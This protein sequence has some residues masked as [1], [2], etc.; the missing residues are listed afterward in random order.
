MVGRVGE[1]REQPPGAPAHALAVGGHH[2][3]VLLAVHLDPTERLPDA[4]PSQLPLAGGPQV[5]GPL[6]LAAAPDQVAG[7]PVGEWRDGGADRAAAA[8][9][10]HGERRTAEPDRERVDQVPDDEPRRDIR[11]WRGI[12]LGHRILL[13]LPQPPRRP[14]DRWASSRAIP[15]AHAPIAAQSRKSPWGSRLATIRSVNPS[16]LGSSLLRSQAPKNTR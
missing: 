4:A 2:P 14:A 9:T 11:V 7:L 10:H 6:G 13:G 5:A 16:L 8:P 12:G 3:V 15:S 1:R